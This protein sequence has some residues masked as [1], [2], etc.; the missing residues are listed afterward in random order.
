MENYAASPTREALPASPPPMFPSYPSAASFLPRSHTTSQRAFKPFLRN[1]LKR[2]PM[3]LLPP[4]DEGRRWGG[5][6]RG[7]SR[8]GTRRLCWNNRKRS[9]LTRKLSADCSSSCRLHPA[10]FGKSP[11]AEVYTGPLFLCWGSLTVREP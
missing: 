7:S 2:R 11:R 8:S 9:Q 4:E 5:T 10:A 3:A 6:K 1:T